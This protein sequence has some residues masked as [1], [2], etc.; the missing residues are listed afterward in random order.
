[1]K[2][3]LAATLG[4]VNDESF[5]KLQGYVHE[6]APDCEVVRL[7]DDRPYP[8]PAEDSE[9]IAAAK[10]ANIIITQYQVVGE[11]AYAALT[12]E[13][14]GVVAF[15]IGY[16]STNPDAATRHGVVV[17]NVPNYCLEEVAAH[18]VALLMA[19]QRRIKNLIR[20]IDDGKWSGGYKCIAPVKRLSRQVIG[21]YGFGKIAKTVAK[22]VSGFG[23]RIIAFDPWVPQ[24]KADELGVTMVDFDTLLTESDYISLHMPLL[25]ANTG[26][27]NKEAFKKMKPSAVF[28]NTARG[29]LCDPEALYE[30]LTTG[31]IY[32]AAIDAYIS[33]PPT[34]IEKKIVELPNVLSTPHVGYYTDDSFEDLL[35]Q[36]AEAAVDI[37]NGRDPGTTINKEIWKK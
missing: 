4:V 2:I 16:N 30:A 25:P 13:L 17:C 27:F 24:E 35:R 37:L 7:A 6:I 23:C 15:G 12:P 29:G 20:W 26:I 1:M 10:G 18:V 32:G 5:D 11:T 8:S 33:E 28:I 3:L 21:L 14:K 36:T 9:F 22:L 19:E 34:G 31:E